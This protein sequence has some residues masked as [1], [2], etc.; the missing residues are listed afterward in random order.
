[1]LRF[2]SCFLQLAIAVLTIVGFASAFAVE[3]NRDQPEAT[4]TPWINASVVLGEGFA[5]VRLGDPADKAER[6]L[7]DPDSGDE[8]GRSYEIGRAHV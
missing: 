8:M 7:G 5:G 1:M 3:P 6:T 2:S 4:P